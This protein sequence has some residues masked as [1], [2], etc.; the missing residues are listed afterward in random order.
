MT[1][2][3]K[4]VDEEEVLRKVPVWLKWLFWVIYTEALNEDVFVWE[5]LSSA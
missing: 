1:W 4:R 3:A 2:N 5:M